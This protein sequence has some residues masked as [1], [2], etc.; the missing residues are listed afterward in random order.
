[1]LLITKPK[2]ESR[3]L[4]CFEDHS[5]SLKS[6]THILL[7]LLL[8]VS[9][10]ATEQAV[11]QKKKKKGKD[12]KQGI[13]KYER[14]NAE[15]LF[16]EAQKFFLIDDYERALTFLDQ[17]L[18]I[19]A[20]NH[21]AFFKKA[22]IYLVT[23]RYSQ[24]LTAIDK[25]L[26][27]EK[28]NRYYYILAAQLHKADNNLEA[29][30]AQ[31][32]L[33]VQ[34]TT[35]YKEFLLDMVDTYVALEDYDK[36]LSTLTLTE[37]EFGTP[38]K[39]A[40]QKKELLLQ[41]NRTDEAL[42]Y[43]ETLLTRTPGNLELTE[44]YITLLV[45]KG[46]TEKATAYLENTSTSVQNIR[47]LL[48]SLYLKTGTSEKA[49]R[50]LNE[51]LEENTLTTSTQL[52]LMRDILSAPDEATVPIA[53]K[54]LAGM[55][56]RLPGNAEVLS[57]QSE[58]L[59][60]LS[61]TGSADTNS[62]S[63]ETI[64]VLLRLKES[65]PGNLANWKKI[66]SYQYQRE[67]WAALLENSEESLI[68]FPNQA[69]LYFYFASATLYSH[70]TAEATA[71]LKQA[72]R[73]GGRNDSLKNLILGKQSEIAFAE[74][75]SQE[76]QSLFSQATASGNH[77][78]LVNNHSFRLA[79]QKID[80]E[81]ALRLATSLVENHPDQLRYIRTK[82]FVLFQNADYA[83][84]KQLLEEAMQRLEGQINGQARELYGDVLIKLDLV[85]EAVEQWQKAK[86]LGNTSEKLS[87]K[88]ANKEYFE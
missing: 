25:A 58:L 45:S 18:E 1:M 84:A 88:I 50:L 40:L 28:D 63:S 76:G 52:R 83:G 73:L 34:N 31:Y 8:L 3:D 56:T 7:I 22:E 78:E 74:G 64:D 62:L 46:N 30:A 61:S 6:I 60:K 77:P 66:L 32:E 47:P 26:Q 2:L 38:D 57:L 53:Q 11:A 55:Q 86:T 5:Y 44:E 36:A 68:Y 9:G 75:Q 81:E 15:Y 87:Q 35:N 43:L 24:G 59:T 12:E 13:T 80:L 17:S 14:A 85:D 67:D 42:Q 10:L 71:L 79:L 4:R 65:D 69:V 51:L 23:Q 20:A 29:A 54:H 19:D 48:A 27:L 16:I 70:D 82:A 41:A 21:A 39:F 49:A 33:M 72:M 37:K